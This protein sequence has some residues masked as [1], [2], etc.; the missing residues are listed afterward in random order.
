MIA[1]ISIVIEVLYLSL[2]RPAGEYYIPDGLILF[3]VFLTSTAVLFDLEKAPE[4]KE[5]KDI[6]AMAF[7]LR[8]AVMLIDVYMKNTIHV[9]G[10]GTDT[11]GF[12][13]RIVQMTINDNYMPQGNF[14]ITI[15]YLF[16][17]IGI[18][19]LYAQFL[20]VMCSLVELVFFVKTI[21]I[22]CD[23]VEKKRSALL[24]IS[25]LPVHI[26]MSAILLREAIIYMFVSIGLYYFIKWYE[27]G[28]DIRFI[29]CIL[30]LIGAMAYHS[31]ILGVIIGITISRTIFD[32][33]NRK[34]KLTTGSVII[35]ILVIFV[36]VFLYNNYG[37]LLFAKFMRLETIADISDGT[38]RGDSSYAIYVGDS[39]T[40]LR[41]LIY[42]V[43]RMMYFM[44]S[45]FPWQWRGV[46]DI[47]AFVF[48]SLIYLVIV[49]KAIGYLIDN[50]SR[51]DDSIRK[52]QIIILLLII[53]STAT[54]VFAW[55]TI[56]S[57]TAL[58][59]RD[60][61]AVIYCLIA[62]VLID[63]N[64]RA[65]SVGIVNGRYIKA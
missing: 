53:C 42:T 49:G 57:G 30:F 36:I 35:G 9:F 43:P 39:S 15:G 50:T 29:A 5:T 51:S 41:M 22:I 18:S 7:F 13:R 63:D 32:A 16:R 23:S 61:M 14:S 44:F 34:I 40:P 56:N 59:H 45:P 20:L 10:S 2:I 55:G 19:R 26:C 12:Y 33:E 47:I 3:F 17:F 38:A 64:E 65:D 52:R 54:F 60:K 8:I 62:A 11:E 37:E 1:T 24:L 27:T 58:R 25:L 6:L 28:N 46:K 48:N 4:Y 21:N 31:G